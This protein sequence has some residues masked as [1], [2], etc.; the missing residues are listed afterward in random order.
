[1][2][3]LF[4]HYVPSSALF[5]LL[6]DVLLLFIS[7]LLAFGLQ[8]RG[9]VQDLELIAPSAL[10]FAL[11]MMLL[12]SALGLY[13]G[14]TRFS[15]LQQKSV[16]VGLSLAL[17][18]PIA[19]WIF[20]VL[21]WRSLGQGPV[22]LTVLVALGIVIAFRG[23]ATRAATVPFIARRVLVIGTGEEALAVQ[24]SIEQSGGP[25]MQVVGFYPVHAHAMD[26]IRVPAD[27][28]LARTA[29]IAATVRSTKADEVVVA[30]RERRGG[31][32]P[33]GDL[34]ECKL[35]GVRVFDLSSFFERTLGQVRVDSLRA[36]WL[37]YG[38]GF[39]QG[40]VRSAIKRLFDISV[41]LAL[42]TLA[43][44]TMILT[45]ILIVIED[46][47]PIFYRQQ[48]VGQG[49]RVFDVIKFRSMRK[50]AEK[51]GRPQWA[52]QND[53]R[54]TRVGR[55]IRKLRID[56][57]PQLWNVFRGEMSLVGPRPERPFFVEQLNQEIPFYAARHSVK[58][59]VTGW[60]QV[61]YHY[62]ASVNDAVEKLQYDLYYVKNHTLF[63]DIV[64]LLE[65]VR[66]VLTGEGAQ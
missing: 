21:P 49:G 27:R 10:T 14:T 19:Y 45:A 32:V 18:V 13:R 43:S 36:S 55:I 33:M 66:V 24:R 12:N 15:T 42:L 30:V 9:S 35:T 38:D 25:V 40:W 48:R 34:L 6:L 37:I 65:T 16:R 59:G 28:I 50:D 62:G 20:Q 26:A 1:M 57:L 63:L 58:P 46:G 41:A 61:R 2:V 22:E 52:A 5:Q 7:I 64:V 4:S 53:D 3:R 47:F 31:A 17:S 44:P 51:D 11:V 8:Y 60:A 39:R 56:E 29:S 54:V 23:F